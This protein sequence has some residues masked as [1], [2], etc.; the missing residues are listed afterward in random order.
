MDSLV[1]L[2]KGSGMNL[3]PRRWGSIPASLALWVFVFLGSVVYGSS[4]TA[5]VITT[6]PA[7]KTINV[8]QTATFAV[9]ATGG[10]LTYQWKKGGVNVVGGSGATTAS[11]T[12]PAA[13][14]GD[15]GAQFMVDVTDAT[16]TTP[17][18]A[19]TLTVNAPPAI[20]T[21][22]GNQT[23]VVGQTA[24]FT[25]VATGGSLTYQWQKGGGNVVGGSGAT[26]AS[27]TTPA[28][29]AGDNNAMFSV[30][31]T[32]TAG[33]ITSNNAKLTVGAA[34]APGITTQPANATIVEG[35]TATL[36]IV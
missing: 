18:A 15:N 36:T 12:T 2:K 27:Y 9:V 19:A 14:A 20:T 22:P 4:A 34:T 5:P 3:K 23:I 25:V 13:V 11:Y 32:N 30:I 1:V 17:S 16:G 10:T 24:T 29:V 33:T 7:N 31:V 6:P 26:T 28:A 8:G 35:P 21:Q